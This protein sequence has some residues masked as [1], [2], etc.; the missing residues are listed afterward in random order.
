MQVYLVTNKVNRKQYVGQ[1]VR[2]LEKRWNSHVSVAMRGKGSYLAHAIKMHSS[3]KFMVETL[4]I[5][6]SKEEMDF[7]EI[8]YIELLK[9]KRPVGYNLTAGGE[10]NL[11][12]KPSEKTKEHMGA[13]KGSHWTAEARERRKVLM[14]EL[15]SN[16]KLSK[17][18]AAERMRGNTHTKGRKI[19]EE[20]KLKR[21]YFKPG[22]QF[23]RKNTKSENG[24]QP[25]G[26]QSLSN[27]EQLH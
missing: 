19:P 6:E 9:T 7:T 25:S 23:A 16:G 18:S 8:F 11:G 3:E 22:N 17:K 15:W 20:E 5:C 21:V 13:P 27:S 1:T 24:G 26:P 4:H 2:S 12:W 14:K 10:G